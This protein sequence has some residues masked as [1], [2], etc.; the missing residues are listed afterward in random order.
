MESE[1][2][3]NVSSFHGLTNGGSQKD[4]G[5]MNKLGEVANHQVC[6]GNVRVDM[7]NGLMDTYGS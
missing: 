5:N 7:L 2:E 4:Q 6:F 1:G 3:G